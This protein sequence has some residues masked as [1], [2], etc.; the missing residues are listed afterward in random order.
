MFHRGGPGSSDCLGWDLEGV[1]G[2]TVDVEERVWRGMRGGLEGRFL[3]AGSRM[4]REKSDIC[5]L[6]WESLFERVKS[7]DQLAHTK[8]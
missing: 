4:S 6:G 3:R 1:E 2:R 5:S 8:F 7:G